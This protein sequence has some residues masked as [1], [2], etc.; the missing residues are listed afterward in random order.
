MNKFYSIKGISDCQE[1]NYQLRNL[2]ETKPGMSI[3]F[4]DRDPFSGRHKYHS[5][6]T[7]IKV[8]PEDY[9]NLFALETFLF[10]LALY[11]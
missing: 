6:T 5:N 4:L 10:R 7:Y 9:D 3:G 1:H 8:V 11:L 2:G